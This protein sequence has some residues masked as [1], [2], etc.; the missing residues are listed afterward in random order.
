MSAVRNL[1]K[2]AVAGAALGA[3][4]SLI[5]VFRDETPEFVYTSDYIASLALHVL[6]RA[7]LGALFLTLVVG[8]CLLI[9]GLYKRIVK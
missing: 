4:A 1:I 8:I 3:G 9:W 6:G 5:S 7:A 2:A